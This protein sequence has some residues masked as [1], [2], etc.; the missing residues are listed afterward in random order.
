MGAHIINLFPFTREMGVKNHQR[1]RS[2]MGWPDLGLKTI[3]DVRQWSNDGAHIH[4]NA[5]HCDTMQ[6]QANT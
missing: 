3:Q 4:A 6:V 5:V 2:S 1:R